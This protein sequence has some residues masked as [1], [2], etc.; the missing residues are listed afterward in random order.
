MIDN[1]LATILPWTIGII[2]A[3]CLSFEGASHSVSTGVALVFY[4]ATLA[5]IRCWRCNQGGFVA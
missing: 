5:L 3:F 2:V 1:V 4:G